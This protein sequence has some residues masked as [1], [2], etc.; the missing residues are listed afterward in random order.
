MRPSINRYFAD[1]AQLVASRSTCVRRAV[2]CVLVDKANRV[3]AT[4]YN[5]VAVGQKHCNDVKMTDFRVKHL[6]FPNACPAAGAMS[7]QNLDGCGAIHAE[8]NAILQCP[9]AQRIERAYVT[10]FPCPTCTKLLLNT[11]CREIVYLNPYGDDAGRKMWIAA[12][13]LAVHFDAE[14]PMIQR[15]LVALFGEGDDTN[16]WRIIV[17]CIC[18]NLASARQARGIVFRIL[19]VWPTPSDLR[20]ADEKL[21]LIL[22]P[23]GLSARRAHYLRTMSAQ[24]SKGVNLIE[25]PGVG[26]YAYESVQVF[27]HGQLPDPLSIA[28][29]KVAAWVAWRKKQLELD[30]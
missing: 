29:R 15:D 1:M 4:G 8:Q 12:G 3:L 27:H 24:W 21:E 9:D 23:L 30:A 26:P 6:T 10:A 25:L 20:Q 18:L 22:R 11:S 14:P 5:G 16:P 28:D 19:Q 13:R 2:G 7:G 17:A